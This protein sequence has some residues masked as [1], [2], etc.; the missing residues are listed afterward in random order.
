MTYLKISFLILITFFTACSKYDYSVHKPK[1][2]FKP[3]SYALDKLNREA[4]GRKYIWAEEGPYC[5][6]CSGLTYYN[7]GSMG[8]EIPRVADE[9]FRSGIPVAKSELKK[10]DLVFFGNGQRA[11]HVG[12]YLGNG[13]FEHASSAKKRVI[14]SSLNN[15]YF[16]RRYMGARR[17]YNF[18]NIERFKPRVV[19]PTYQNLA[20]AL[21][22]TKKSK[23]GKY[24]ILAG[25]YSSYPSELITKLELSGLSTKV[26]RENGLYKVLVGPFNSINDA[27]RDLSYNPTLLSNVMVVKDTI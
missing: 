2:R 8:I 4:L 7:F 11:T 18:Y 9:Q 25:A 27:K 15:P 22:N 12:I 20:V 17:Y 16:K 26:K 10:G 23:G 24:Y 19:E 13:K 3:S 6:D 14:V 5:F 1:V 21:F